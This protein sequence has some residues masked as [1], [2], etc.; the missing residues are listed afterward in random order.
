M[1]SSDFSG[2]GVNSCFGEKCS[3]CVFGDLGV[4]VCED[5]VFLLSILSVDNC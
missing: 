1:E 3:P 4:F 2:G 5:L